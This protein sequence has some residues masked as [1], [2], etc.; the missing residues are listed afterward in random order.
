MCEHICERILCQL[1]THV[2]KFAGRRVVLFW[3]AS[4]DEYFSLPK[5]GNVCNHWQ[6]STADQSRILGEVREEI[7][8]V[9]HEIDTSGDGTVRVIFSDDS[10]IFFITGCALVES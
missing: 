4:R 10:Q 3:T 6:L 1:D 2:D 5:F 9:F 8:A 7:T